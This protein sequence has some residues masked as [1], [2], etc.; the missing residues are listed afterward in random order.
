M[1]IEDLKIFVDVVRY[2]S[3]NIA[4]EMNYTTPQNLSKIIKRMEDELG[5]V[6]FNRS[7]KGSDLTKEGEAFYIQIVQV[8]QHYQEALLAIDKD[9]KQFNREEIR[10]IDRLSVICSVGAL[11]C[12]VMNTYNDMLKKYHGLILETEEVYCLSPQKLID[13]IMEEQYDIIACYI[14]QEGVNYF[15][16]QLKNYILVHIIFDELVLVVSKNN[17][18]S[19]RSIVSLNELQDKPFVCFMEDPLTNSF[20]EG[21]IN[22]Q[23]YTNSHSKALEQIKMS[24]DYCGLFFKSYYL[25]NNKDFSD[26][27]ELRMLNLNTKISGTYIIALNFT[28]FGDKYV[29]EFVSK[30]GEC[31]YVIE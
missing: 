6:L 12:A 31:L 8:L 9:S 18:L 20:M 2:H 15:Q 10:G 29:S 26:D 19:R 14:P 16:K 25:V 3:M 22:Y 4:A 5:V 27:G 1:R 7:K 23:F 21:N 24:T 17:P 13:Q 11:S 30:L 28:R